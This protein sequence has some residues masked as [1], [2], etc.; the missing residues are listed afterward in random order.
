MAAA[1]S[2][3]PLAAAVCASDKLIVCF[4]A[5]AKLGHKATSRTHN[6]KRMTVS[7][8]LRSYSL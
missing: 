2:A 5:K 7:P 6:T 4:A 3:S 8:V 1:A